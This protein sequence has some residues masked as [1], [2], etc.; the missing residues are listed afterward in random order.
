MRDGVMNGP[1]I[2]LTFEGQIDS[3]RDALALN[4]T[5]IPAYTV[6]NFF[7]KI[8]VVGLLLGGGWNEG[9]FAINYR[10]AGRMSAP[11]VSVNP[12]TVAPG[13]LRKIFGAFDNA[14]SAPPTR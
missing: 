6:N 9:L 2:G 10:I 8:P 13:F 1:N 7:A 12:L 14:T 3:D 4:G 5:F 11:Q